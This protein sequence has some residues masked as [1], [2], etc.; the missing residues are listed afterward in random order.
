MEVHTGTVGYS[1]NFLFQIINII[2]I[3][4]PVVLGII[5]TV[6]AVRALWKKKKKKRENTPMKGEKDS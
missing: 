1:W 4:V 6:L 3:A 5:I 2:V